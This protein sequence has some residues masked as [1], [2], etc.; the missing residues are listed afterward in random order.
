MQGKNFVYLKAFSFP[1]EVKK[2]EKMANNAIGE[3]IKKERQKLG[4]TQSELGRML[5]VSK[6]TLCGW[7]NGR[8]IPDIITLGRL[9]NICHVSIS[10]LLDTNLKPNVDKHVEDTLQYFDR[11]TRQEERIVRAFQRASAEKRKAIEVLLGI[12]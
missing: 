8:I 12:K 9:A 3:Q 5:D 10:A 11:L 1:D 2:C 6:Q 7:E 4:L